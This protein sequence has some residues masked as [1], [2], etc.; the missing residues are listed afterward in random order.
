MLRVISYRVGLDGP[1][2]L[3]LFV[4]GLLGERRREVAPGAGPGRC[5][6]GRQ[7]MF[8][9]GLVPGP[10][11]MWPGLRQEH[12]CSDF[13]GCLAVFSC[14]QLSPVRDGSWGA[15]GSRTWTVR[16]PS[17]RGV[18]WTSPAWEWATDRTMDNPRPAPRPGDDAVAESARRSVA[19]RRR[20]GSNKPGTS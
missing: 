9:A 8:C 1:A 20:K 11:R 5:P 3:A 19:R 2:R 7:A 16:P 15:A 6:A 13:G 17:C 14:I 4:S 10:A 12:P 18:A